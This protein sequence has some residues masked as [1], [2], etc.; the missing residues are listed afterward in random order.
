MAFLRNHAFI[1]SMHA[2]LFVDF[3]EIALKHYKNDIIMAVQNIGV[4]IDGSVTHRPLVY[5]AD[6]L[7]FTFI[8]DKL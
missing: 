5:M 7:I 1:S 3:Q 6:P 2:D 4:S 8:N